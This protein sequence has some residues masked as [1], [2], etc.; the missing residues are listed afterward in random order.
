MS[1]KYVIYITLKR[2]KNHIVCFV[3]NSLRIII[4]F[5]GRKNV[6][7]F[8]LVVQ[9]TIKTMIPELICMSLRMSFGETNFFLQR[10]NP[11]F[12]L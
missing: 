10:V 7:L 9:V 1:Y 8:F 5:N 2:K 11:I 6:E 12:F 4:F 3:I